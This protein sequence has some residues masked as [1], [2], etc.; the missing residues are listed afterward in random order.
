[1]IH[2]ACLLCKLLV[3]VCR[4][5]PTISN[6]S[7]RTNQAHVSESLGLRLPEERH[8]EVMETQVRVSIYILWSN[9]ILQLEF[10]IQT[11]EPA[12]SSQQQIKII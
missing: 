7:S 3:S 6:S 10:R 11:V 9:K 2:L 8:K 12:A 4:R 5:L 1:M